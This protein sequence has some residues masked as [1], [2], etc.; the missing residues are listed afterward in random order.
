MEP[1]CVVTFRKIHRSDG[2]LSKMIAVWNKPLPSV[3]ENYVHTEVSI[4]KPCFGKLC[5]YM[6]YDD[7][8]EKHGINR[9]NHWITFGVDSSRGVYA[10]LDKYE[11]KPDW[12][13]KW[14]FMSV[15]LSLK[16]LELLEAFLIK[17][18]KK[19]GFSR[20]TLCWNYFF[21]CRYLIPMGVVKTGQLVTEHEYVPEGRDWICSELVMTALVYSKKIKPQT[22]PGSLTPGDLHQELSSL[23]W[24]APMK[25]VP[26]GL[27]SRKKHFI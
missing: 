5:P 15:S 24:I 4:R 14:E 20:F 8:I 19:G 1:Q 10:Q 22:N 16:E 2:S 25:H 23:D 3:T 17:Q 21:A 27:F 13:M 18:W 6:E 26:T 11:G 7:N 12:K 9:C